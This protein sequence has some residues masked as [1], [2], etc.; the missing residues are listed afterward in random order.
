MK[1]AKEKGDLSFY[2]TDIV[3]YIYIYI[4]IYFFSSFLLIC[5]GTAHPCDNIDEHTPAV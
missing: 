3:I 4:N 5:K 1:A 2:Y